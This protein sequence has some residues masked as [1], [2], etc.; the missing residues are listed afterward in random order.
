[1]QNIYKTVDHI[2]V[3]IGVKDLK[4]LAFTILR[5]LWMKWLKDMPLKIDQV[6]LRNSKYIEFTPKGM[7]GSPQ[8]MDAITDLF[9]VP[10]VG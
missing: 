3:Q 5:P 7:L 4:I 1:L 8:D 9:Y 10:V 2:L 6:Q